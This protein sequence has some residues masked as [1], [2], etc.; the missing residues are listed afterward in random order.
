MDLVIMAAGMG[1]RFGGLKQVE[2]MNENGEFILDYSVF[3]AIATGFD[4]VVFIIK[5]E[6]YD[7]FRDTVGKRIENKIKV[8]YVFQKTTDIP[9]GFTVP[10]GREKPWGT[11][12]AILA[13]KDVVKSNFAVINADDFYGRDALRIVADFFNKKKCKFIECLKGLCGKKSAD[14]V[15]VGYRV[16]NTMTENGS[17]KRGVCFLDKKDRLSGLVESVVERDANGNILASPLDGTTPF[18]IPE[19][20][21]VSMN[22]WGFTP[23][24]F[25]ILEREF[26]PFLEKGIKENPLKCEFLLPMII[27]DAVANKE[28]SVE[29]V[30]TSSVWFGVTYKEDKPTV[31]AALKKMAEDGEYPKN[32]WQ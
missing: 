12:H 26:T 29:V 22:L 20:R 15:L 17:V 24:V 21:M 25:E 8:E 32:L 4:R 19:D 2:P 31:V 3:D 6:N 7:L 16:K 30:E 23:K 1:S 14:Y 28:V 11:G 13:C 5:E 18:E 10:E 9:A 27:Q